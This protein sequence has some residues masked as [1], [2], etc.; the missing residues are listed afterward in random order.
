MGRSSTIP[1]KATTSSR[2]KNTS[3]G[4]P[5]PK[6]TP[7]E[8][9]HFQYF[10]QPFVSQGCYTTTAA[11]A[12][13]V[14]IPSDD[15]LSRALSDMG[16]NP[17][18][19]LSPIC[20]ILLPNS[21]P[22]KKM[23]TSKKSVGSTNRGE[24]QRKGIASKG[25][26]SRLRQLLQQP[27]VEVTVPQDE[28]PPPPQPPMLRSPLQEIITTFDDV[29]ASIEVSRAPPLEVPQEMAATLTVTP[30][31]EEEEEAIMYSQADE[32]DVISAFLRY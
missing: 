21:P 24:N 15:I 32:P 31:V 2:R 22:V 3:V 9:Q 10:Q 17:I 5:M 18:M 25:S 28:A 6:E 4:K 1:K 23:A 7:E 30:Q 14:I 29:V 27:A 8:R 11:S 20:D 12:M 16:Y 13:D 19:D 26:T